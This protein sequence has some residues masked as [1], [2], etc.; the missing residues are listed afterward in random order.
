MGKKYNCFKFSMTGII[1]EKCTI[2]R[3]IE[4]IDLLL[5]T[6]NYIHLY[7]SKMSNNI[8]INNLN[9]DNTDEIVV[10]LYGKI[11]RIFY[12]LNN[13]IL[14][15]SMPFHYG[16]M[17]YGVNDPCGFNHEF[18]DY[19]TGMRIDSQLIN[20]LKL[21]LNCHFDIESIMDI[22]DENYGYEK[23]EDVMNIFNKLLSYDTGYLRYDYD[24]ERANKFYHPLNHI[25]VNFDDRSSFKLGLSN[26]CT[27][28]E[29][30][31]IIDKEKKARY[32]MDNPK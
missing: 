14:S 9:I 3:K 2:R 6:I 12:C 15:I 1:K 8:D 18:K 11:N 22:L 32:L 31:S 27:C 19:D 23:W 29:L 13:K 10:V 20:C 30:I 28:E 16:L 21:L 4:V 24:E 7:P 5:T 26:R 25:D 17:E